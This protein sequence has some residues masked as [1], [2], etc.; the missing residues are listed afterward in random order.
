MFNAKE[1]ALK[2]R[3]SLREKMDGALDL[4]TCESNSDFPPRIA[5]SMTRIGKEGNRL[6][7]HF[8]H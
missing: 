6:R 3:H 8:N 5:N 1:T 4:S 2:M 7:S